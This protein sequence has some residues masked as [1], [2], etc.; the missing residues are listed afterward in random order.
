MLKTSLAHDRQSDLTN[1]KEDRAARPNV[2]KARWSGAETGHQWRFQAV[3]FIARAGL[4]Y[5]APDS[6]IG[7][8]V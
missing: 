3:G 5:V 6:D 2:H 4:S 8:R 7:T 1:V